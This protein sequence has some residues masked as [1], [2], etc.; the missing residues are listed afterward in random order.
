LFTTM[1]AGKVVVTN[2]KRL[3]FDGKLNFDSVSKVAGPAVTRIEDD[4]PSDDEIIAALGDDATIIINKEIP[5]TAALIGRFPPT[6]KL[7]CEAGTGFNN[8]ALD[9]AAARGIKVTNVPAYS[10]EA[11]AQLVATF[12]LNFSCSLG[13]QQRMLQNGDKSNFKGS[14]QVPHFELQGKT[15]GLIGGR[16][17]IGSATAKLCIALGMRVIV[18]SRSDAPSKI[19]G[20]GITSSVED[21]L[22]VSDF[23][24]LH[25]P[26]T[27]STKHLINA[28]TLKIMK[29]TA[30]L[31][32]TARGAIVDEPALIEALSASPPTIAGAGLDVQELEPPADDSALYTLPNVI[33]TP[34]I[35]WKRVETRQRLVDAVADNIAAFISGTPTNIVA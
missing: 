28:A 9:A 19:D 33:L 1:P 14:L 12:L 34:H 24:S 3:D 7:I 29:P 32:N 5:I 35:G 2:A 16:G 4:H 8:I 25:C 13:L 22:K 6:M 23:V 18:S 27:A 11:V 20:V 10:T 31:I 21:L 17:N 26:L 15:I 30:Y